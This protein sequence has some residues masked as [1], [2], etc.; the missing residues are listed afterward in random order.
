MSAP[1]GP[2][3]RPDPIAV[4]VLALPADDGSWWAVHPTDHPGTSFDPNVGGA[5]AR[6]L[7]GG[8]FHPFDDAD[9]AR[10]PTRYLADHPNAAFAE[11]LFRGRPGK[12]RASLAAI[13]AH[14]LSQI[15]LV[16]ALRVA[17]LTGRDP[18]TALGRALGADDSEVYP[19]LRVV[20]AQ[21]HAHP[22]RLDGIVWDGVQLATPGMRCLVLFG[23]RVDAS[24]DLSLT[25]TVTIDEGPGL[26]R[27]VAAADVRGVPLPES[28]LAR[29]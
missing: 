26:G 20:A 29:R 25:A 8:R 21:V 10:V 11:V 19:A 18:A 9:G 13:R 22:D 27:L 23:D 16:R 2:P 17:D 6:P 24:V 1:N 3:S 28:V 4:P 15:R 7:P 12:R 14:R 5:P